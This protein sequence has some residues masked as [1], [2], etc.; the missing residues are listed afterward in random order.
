MS[1]QDYYKILNVSSSAKADEIKKAYHALA[2]KYHPDVNK[3]SKSAEEKLKKINE[4]Y[5]VLKNTQKRRAYD[6]SSKQQ[7]QMRTGAR[8]HDD[9]QLFRRRM[10]ALCLIIFYF[11]FLSTGLNKRHPFDIQ[12][13]ITESGKTFSCTIFQAKDTV[14][15]KFISSETAQKLLFAAVKKDFYS[16]IEFELKNGANPN[17]TDESGYSLLMRAQSVRTAQLLIENG[18]DVNYQA[19]D[20]YTA[21]ALA[22]K[23]DNGLASILRQNGARLIWKKEINRSSSKNK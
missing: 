4:A 13:I 22:F 17:L 3:N 14:I 2:K 21:Y 6:Q 1:G 10:V 9:R 16:L 8:F 18:A 12:G 23:F 11:L 15:R 5:A 7:K 19:P 20:G